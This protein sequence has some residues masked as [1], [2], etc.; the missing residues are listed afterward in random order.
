MCCASAGNHFPQSPGRGTDSVK[1]LEV[2]SH[3]LHR[4]A[5]VFLISDFQSNRDAPNPE[6][7]CAGR[8]GKQIAGTISSPCTS[9]TRASGCCPMSECS[10][11]KTPKP[12]NSLNS[13]R[14]IRRFAGSSANKRPAEWSGWSAIFDQRVDTLQLKTDAPTCRLAAVLQV[15]RTQTPMSRHSDYEP[16]G[17][18]LRPSCC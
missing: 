15:A 11:W 17:R 12:A 9:K 2:A 13:I 4:R 3:V 10:R 1:A 7:I 5:V 16:L 14:R 6:P 8:C 18:L